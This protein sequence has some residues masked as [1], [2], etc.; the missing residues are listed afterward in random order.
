[1]TSATTARTF[2]RTEATRENYTLG[3]TEQ[4][5]R[6]APVC[7]PAKREVTGDE[8][9]QGMRVMTQAAVLALRGLAGGTLVVI[10]ALISE[11]VSPKA[12]AGLFAAAPTVAVASLFVII[13]TEGPGAARQSVTGMVVGAIAMVGCCILAAATIP[14]VQALKGSVAAWL[15]WIAVDLALYWGVFLGAR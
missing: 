5:A 14:R 12:F 7:P 13:A 2:R 8:P 6:V 10:S 3:G 1:M 9:V 15:G 11:A 4:R